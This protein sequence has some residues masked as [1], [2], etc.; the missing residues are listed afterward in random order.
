MRAVVLERQGQP[1]APVTL[2]DPEPA[3]GQLLLTVGACGVCRTDLH[4]RDAEIAA[5]RLPVVLGHQIVARTEDGRRVGVPWL[6]WTDGC[7]AYCTSGR[8]NLCERARFT[9]RDID[10]GFAELTVADERFCL[11]L[12]DQ[13]SDQQ[14]APLLCGGLIGFRALRLA[15][16]AARVGLYGFGSAAHMICQVG[17]FEGRRMFAFTRPGDQRGRQFARE[18]G[19]VWAGASG[20]TPPEPLDAAIIFASAGE[21]VPAALRVLAPGGIVVCAGIYMSD[22]PSFQYEL[23][24]HERTIRSVA[25]LTRRDGE[26]FLALAVRIPVVTT[27]TSYPLERAEQ[28]LA[29]L[30]AG[31]FEGTAVVIP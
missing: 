30:R 27:V 28:A 25:N 7:C 21:L 14:A 3:D 16:D 22:I 6:G 11:P 18:L 31:A 1:L 17:V 13:L 8:E 24:W 12:P 4:L 2:P 19:A 23:L 15:G 29:D 26:E 10:G 20:D 9:G 5:T